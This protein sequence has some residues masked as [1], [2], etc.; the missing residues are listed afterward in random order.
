MGLLLGLI[1]PTLIILI[2]IAILIVIGRMKNKIDRTEFCFAVLGYFLLGLFVPIVATFLSVRGL[3]YNFGPDKDVC[4]TGAGV[5]IFFGYQ[6]NLIG[7][8]IVAITLFP[9]GRIER[10][11]D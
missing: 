1:I 9:S 4:A 10:K 8:P 2:P 5:F 6:I 11:E 3:V 7:V